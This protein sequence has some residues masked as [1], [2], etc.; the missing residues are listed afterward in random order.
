MVKFCCRR[1]LAFIA[2]A[3][4]PGFRQFPG[5]PRTDCFP[6]LVVLGLISPGW[7]WQGVTA[8]PGLFPACRGPNL[9]LEALH[10]P[11]RSLG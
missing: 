3:G 1:Q 7:G 4:I 11:A 10:L 9:L 2:G 6:R 8:R 5:S